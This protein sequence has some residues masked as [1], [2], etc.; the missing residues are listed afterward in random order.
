MYIHKYILCSLL[1]CL[2]GSLLDISM[3]T[4]A[5]TNMYIY[6]VELQIKWLKCLKEARNTKYANVIICE[7]S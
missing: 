3:K 2:V 6:A 5:S 7:H 1:P 4:Y